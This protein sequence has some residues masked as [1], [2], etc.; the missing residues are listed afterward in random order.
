MTDPLQSAGYKRT[1]PRQRV[2]DA[3]RSAT[4]PLQAQEVAAR[5]GTS[6][7]S[8][9]RVLGLLVELGVVSET[10]EAASG[11]EPGAEGRTRRYALC[12]AA[13]QHHHHVV[14]RTCH[15]AVDLTSDALEQ[16]LAQVASE[17]ERA[18]G[19]HVDEH[20]LTLRGECAACQRKRVS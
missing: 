2:L 15:A 18:A 6:P 7:A 17:L 16:A 1:Q 12:S 5:A 4:T 14:C 10:S 8:T 13:G 11:R 19:F 20:D 9:Y 3:L